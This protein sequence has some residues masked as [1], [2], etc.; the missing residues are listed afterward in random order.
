[1]Y[2]N[3]KY[4]INTYIRN[5]PDIRTF[6]DQPEVILHVGLVQAKPDVFVD[7]IRYLLVLSTAKQLILIGVGVAPA[8][9]ST[10]TSGTPRLD[11]QLYDTGFTVPSKE[12]QSIVGTRD[13]RIFMC[14]VED[15]YLYELVYR[16]SEGWFNNKINLI[17]HSTAGGLT[18]ILPTALSSWS[19]GQSGE[20]MQSYSVYSPSLTI[21]QIASSRSSS[22]M[23]ENI[24][25]R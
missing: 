18:S 22:T 14:G 17:N 21:L 16:R 13:G 9:G 6:E 8:Q 4:F 5:R 11:V 2:F 10:S 25:T 19:I 1:L 15:G 7:E 20:G 12:M 24:S 23:T 3:L